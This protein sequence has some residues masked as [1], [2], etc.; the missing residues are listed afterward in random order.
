MDRSWYDSLI[1]SPLTPPRPVFGIVWPILYILIAI[2]FI[3]FLQ[4]GGIHHYLALT[5]FIIQII[6]N[7]SW[8]YVFFTAKH[9][10]LSCIIIV[11]LLLSIV[12]VMITFYKVNPVSTYLLIPYVIWVS[13]AT[14]LNVYIYIYN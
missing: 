7:V 11:L 2:S 9:L 3:L 5:F 12:A 4:Q 13:F 1:Q 14:Y 10:L 6:L 8:S